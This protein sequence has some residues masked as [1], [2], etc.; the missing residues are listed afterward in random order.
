[1]AAKYEADETRHDEEQ[2]IVDI[3]EQ[4]A[5]KSA[6]RTGSWSIG[7]GQYW[8]W[9]QRDISS[10]SLARMHIVGAGATGRRMAARKKER[11]MRRETMD[12]VQ[13]RARR[14][15]QM[16]NAL[17][18]GTSWRK[19]TQMKMCCTQRCKADECESEQWQQSRK[20]KYRRRSFVSH[21]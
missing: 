20:E 9:V 16:M 15:E 5:Y 21:Y 19:C 13:R 1:M 17:D 4:A 6:Q 14:I 3:A 8:N 7:K 2:G 10:T 18:E 12:T 11:V